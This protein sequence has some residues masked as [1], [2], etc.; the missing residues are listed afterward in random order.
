MLLQV[1]WAKAF[2]VNIHCIGGQKR[3][4][5]IPLFLT[6]L[7]FTLISLSL[8]PI[9]QPIM[10]AVTHGSNANTHPGDVVLNA[11]RAKRT[12]KEVED[13]KAQAKAKATAAK[14]E[15]AAK[16]RAIISTI[17]ALKA[18]VERQEAAIR[19]Y[20]NRPDLHD[21]SP[22]AAQK[23]LTQEVPVTA[24]EHTSGNHNSTG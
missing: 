9:Y 17:A 16:R 2:Y 1:P 18:T 19:A 14:Q 3:F 6:Q 13:K 21:G 5:I 10:P 24:R 8:V 11:R 23:K 20:T 15:G 4:V 7:S 22:N 12:T